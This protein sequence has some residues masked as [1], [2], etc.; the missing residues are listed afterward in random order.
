MKLY[1]G[2]SLAAWRDIEAAGAIKPRSATNGSGR[3]VWHEHPSNPEMIYLTDCYGMYFAGVASHEHDSADAS[4]LIEVEVDLENLFPDED[5]LESASRTMTEL[6]IYGASLAE[7]TEYFR[8]RLWEFPHIAEDSLKNLGT[9]AHNGEIPISKIT[10]VVGFNPIPLTFV[11]DPTITMLN[12]SIMSNYYESGTAWIMDGTEVTGSHGNGTPEMW[13][14]LREEIKATTIY[15][16]A[17][18]AA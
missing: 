16:N 9:V 6:P 17:E 11:F 14:E 8:E 1:H 15:E 18:E 3:K 7:R 2:T 10:R 12:H 13:A 4:V 5:F